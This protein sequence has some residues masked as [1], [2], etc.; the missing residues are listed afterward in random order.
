MSRRDAAREA[1]L[2]LARLRNSIPTHIDGKEAILQM[3]E[4]KETARNE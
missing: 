2:L 3:T 1:D 4:E